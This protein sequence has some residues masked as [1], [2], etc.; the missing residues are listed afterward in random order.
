MC[1]ALVCLKPVREKR[2]PDALL[3]TEHWV[4]MRTVQSVGYRT[5]GPYAP[6][7]VNVSHVFTHMQTFCQAVDLASTFH[8]FVVSV[9][10]LC[11][12]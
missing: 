1:V 7:G 6:A 8:G 10:I 4:M 12:A 3:S 9:V 5:H 2:R 11:R